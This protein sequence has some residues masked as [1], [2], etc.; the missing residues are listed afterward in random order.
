MVGGPALPEG[1]A[2]RELRLF[3]LTLGAMSLALW[4]FTVVLAITAYN[5]GG[6]AAVTLAVVARVL[7]AAIAGPFT[8]LLGD[9]R[10]R[11]ATLLALTSAATAA[12]VAVMLVTALDGP[13][14]LVLALAAAFSALTSGQQPAQI[15]LLPGLAQNPRQLAVA[16]SL[17][18][19]VGNGAYS[20][21]A[22][23]GGA[24]AA[25]VSE[26]AGFA[27]ALAGSVLALVALFAMRI[28]PVPPHREALAGASLASSS[29]SASARSS[30]PPPCATRSAC[31]QRS[32]SSTA[33]STC[34]WSSSR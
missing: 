31:S 15:A 9:R 23:A 17:R 11:R 30:R 28:D 25:G 10:S 33:C 26:P 12:L 32:G 8:A 34:S 20:L 14:A 19:G 21:G 1:L 27:V 4:A 6:T 24:A 2:T 29:R 22:L 7:P 16:N 3:L 13:F 18:Q 5:A